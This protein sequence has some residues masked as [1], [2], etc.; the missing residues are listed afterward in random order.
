MSDTHAGATRLGTENQ[1]IHTGH[2]LR[3]SKALSAL[4]ILQLI[5]ALA[6]LGLAGFV[7]TFISYSGASL[8]LFVASA[9]ILIV[10]Y[11]LLATHRFTSIYNY[12]AIACLDIFLIIFWVAAWITSAVQVRR[13]RGRFDY[14]GC[15]NFFCRRD[16]LELEER[17]DLNLGGSNGLEKRART[18]YHNFRAVYIAATVLAAVE[19]VLFIITFCYT[20]GKILKHHDEG[21]H[22]NAFPKKHH[23]RDM[24]MHTPGQT[25]AGTG[26][27]TGVGTGAGVGGNTAHTGVHPGAGEPVVTS[28]PV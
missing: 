6:I 28:N 26:A 3:P 22:S 10:L 27:A 19:F 18:S 24:E 1:E 4:R 21:G 2:V 13:Y 12:W 16:L 8:D 25:G 5:I 15:G 14:Y 20:L 23:N 17:D 7:V 9:T 11:I